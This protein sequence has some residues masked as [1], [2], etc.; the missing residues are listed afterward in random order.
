MQLVWLCKAEERTI[1]D[2]EMHNLDRG[3]LLSGRNKLSSNLD[4]RLIDY[5][6]AYI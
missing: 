6:E 1:Y 3:Q 2:Q 4:S 5:S